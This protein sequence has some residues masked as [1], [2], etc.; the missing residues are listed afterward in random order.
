MQSKSILKT[1]L[2]II[3][4]IVSCENKNNSLEKGLLVHYTFNDDVK[5]LVVGS[6]GT[7]FVNDISFKPDKFEKENSACYFNGVSS[8]IW[9]DLKD[10]PEYRSPITISW[11]FFQK[12]SQ[13]LNHD[14]D[15]ANLIVLVDTVQG[16]GIQFGLRGPVY[17]TKGFDTWLWGGRTLLEANNPEINKWHHCIY[18]YDGLIQRFYIDGEEVAKSK[19]SPKE[20]WPKQ[21][22]FGN[23][24]SG[25]QYFK[26]MI[27]EVRIYNRTLN[28]DEIN[29]L[30]N[31][32]F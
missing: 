8:M 18:S 10:F 27:D 14:I 13:N 30:H 15:A 19:Y 9:T 26:G 23:Y 6:T 11:W 3:V 29:A 31:L 4:F 20:G 7:T 21:L 16:K 28:I 17:Q 25:N 12:I 24:P 2:L 1:C 5:N 22:M 32:K